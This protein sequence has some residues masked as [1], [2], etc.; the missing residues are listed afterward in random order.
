MSRCILLGILL[1]LASACAD[2]SSD[3]DETTPGTGD[4]DSSGAQ[5]DA[6]STTGDDESGGGESGGGE[7]EG[8]E[9]GEPATGEQLYLQLCAACHGADAM[10]TALGYELRHP[11][12]TLAMWVVR[13]GRPGDEFPTSMMAAYP[14]E[15][16]SDAE[17]ESI[18][19]FLDSFPQ[20][21]TPE[22]LYLDYCGNCHGPDALGGVVGKNIGDKEDGDIHEKVREGENTGNPGVRALYMPRFETATLSDAEIDAIAGFIAGL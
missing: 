10:G 22:G 19:D 7:S 4:E 3:L 2:V 8:A 15:V 6:E 11:P 5:G 16:L 9:T 13:N 12:R 18:F 1:A 14:P 17:L 20:P 21:A